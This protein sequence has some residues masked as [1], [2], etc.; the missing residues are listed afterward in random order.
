MK[1]IKW[2]LLII[3]VILFIIFILNATVIVSSRRKFKDDYNEI[4]SDAIV[5][6]GSS[7][8]EGRPGAILKDRLDKAIELYKNGVSNKIIMS[9][10]STRV[11]H[12]EVSVMMNY[13]VDNGVEKED[14]I[15][16][17]AG[18]STYD[19]MYRVSN[20]FNI[21]NIVVVTQKYHLYRSVYIADKLGM[22]V[23]GVETTDI[24]YRGETYRRV[25]EIIARCKDVF[26]CIIKP[27]AMYKE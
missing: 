4:R 24:T 18:V 11:D 14:I 26:K 6:L 19:T 10:D 21:K 22:D 2:V 1:I 23:C 7:I 27:S 9:G 15:L 25:R 16:D 13:A 3:F 12:D 17:Y 5:V 20:V 8:I